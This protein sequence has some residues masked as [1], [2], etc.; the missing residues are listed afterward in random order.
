MSSGTAKHDRRKIRR[1]IGPQAADALLTM[2]DRSIEI[3][4]FLLLRHSFWRRVWWI[5]TGR[6]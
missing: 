4:R 1:A 6:F 5:V 3:D 2:E